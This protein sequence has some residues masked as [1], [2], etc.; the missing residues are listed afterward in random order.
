M[1]EHETG[2]RSVSCYEKEHMAYAMNCG[3]EF[4]GRL[5]GQVKKGVKNLKG[6]EAIS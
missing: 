5:E 2:K 1:F 6:S 3:A 4:R